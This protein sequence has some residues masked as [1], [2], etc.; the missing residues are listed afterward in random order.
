LLPIQ[1]SEIAL[2]YSKKFKENTGHFFLFRQFCRESKLWQWFGVT[3]GGG[4]KSRL[5]FELIHLPDKPAGV[6]GKEKTGGSF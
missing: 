3:L 5:A 1:Q 2:F 4:I 6:C